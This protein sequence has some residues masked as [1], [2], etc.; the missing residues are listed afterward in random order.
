MDNIIISVLIAGLGLAIS[1]SI[2]GCFVVWRK[3][4]YFADSLAHSSLL[5]VALGLFFNL[6]LHILILVVAAVFTTLLIVLE[7]KKIL[8][9]D[10][11]LGVLSYGFLAGGVIIISYID[12]DIDLHGFLFGDILAINTTDIYL[13]YAMLVA[14]IWFVVS[15]FQKLVLITISEDIAK[16][17]GINV[18]WLKLG[19]MFMLAFFVVITSQLIGVLLIGA[20]LIIPVAAARFVSS[21]ITSMIWTSM[22]LG[23][24]AMILGIF[25]SIWLDSPTGPSVVAI[26]SVFFMLFFV[27]FSIKKI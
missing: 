24:I 12:A 11:L 23:S 20:M 17:E 9:Y 13:I 5:G 15:N 21:S 14:I 8:H 2:L 3:M 22:I 16:A 1:A 7:H 4:S 19:F 25:A 18:F 6:N 10:S 26:S 27:V